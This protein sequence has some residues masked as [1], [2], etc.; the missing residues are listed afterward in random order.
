MQHAEGRHLLEYLK[1]LSGQQRGVCEA[2]GQHEGE[3]P[4]E[5]V[6]AQ[7]TGVVEATQ[8]HLLRSLLRRLVPAPPAA[9]DR[10]KNERQWLQPGLYAP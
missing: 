5:G 8:Q 3:G 4:R 1:Q 9:G 2:I 10:S 6:V 7:Y